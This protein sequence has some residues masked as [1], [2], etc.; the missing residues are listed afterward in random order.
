MLGDAARRF[1]KQILLQVLDQLWKEHLST[2][3][4]LRQGISLRGYAG[5]N[6]KQEYKREAFELF[7]SMLHNMKREFIAFLSMVEIRPQDDPD[8]IEKQRQQELENEV[9]TAEH[10]DASTGGVVSDA[11]GS[12]GQVG[13]AQNNPHV[14][15][16]R[17]VGRNEACPCGSGKKYKHCHGVLN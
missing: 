15:D 4:H 1:E 16:G 2:M 5:R 14:R 11:E 10:P 13:D 7:Q 8:I 3:D 9:L 17:K 12:D 6:P